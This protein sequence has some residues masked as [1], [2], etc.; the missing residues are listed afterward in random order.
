MLYTHV[1]THTHTDT[2]T[3]THTVRCWEIMAFKDDLKNFT[4]E[5]MR[6]VLRC[7][8]VAIRGQPNFASR[9]NLVTSLDAQSIQLRFNESVAKYKPLCW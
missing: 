3:H 8:K 9:I 6:E 4:L 7:E 5:N 2:H 1:H